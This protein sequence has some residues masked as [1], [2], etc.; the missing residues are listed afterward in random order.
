M[1]RGKIYIFNISAALQTNSSQYC[2]IFNL[3][4][5]YRV[6]T[7]NDIRFSAVAPS[8]KGYSGLINNVG[9]VYLVNPN[10]TTAE[11]ITFQVVIAL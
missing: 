1:R 9:D 2:V 5:K 4:S 3:P 6:P 10:G 8:G 11:N 7:N